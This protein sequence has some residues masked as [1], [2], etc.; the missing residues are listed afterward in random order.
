MKV[1]IYSRVFPPGVGGMERFAVDLADWLTEQGHDVTVA[2]QSPACRRAD[3]ARPYRVLREPNPVAVIAAA[4]R[5]DVV[6]VNGL[7]LR[8]ILPAFAAGR[9]PVVTHHGHHA[10]CPTGLAWVG[11]RLCTAG[12]KPGPCAAC[13]VRGTMAWGKV[14]AH[15]VGLRAA[16]RNVCV[17][18]YLEARLGLTESVAIYNPVARRVPSRPSTDSGDSLLV[19]FAGRLVAEKGLDVLLRALALVPEAQL[20]MAGDGP[21][22]F[23]W[24][25]LAEVLG[26]GT[27]V[28]FRGALTV[29]GVAEL[30]SR[31]ALVCVPSL[32]DEPF[33]Y[34]AA[35]AMAM[36]KA[37]V[38]TPRGALR[39]LL[40]DGRGFVAGSCTPAALANAIRAALDDEARRIRA[41]R[42]AEDF[43]RRELSIDVVGP[44]YLLVYEEA[45]A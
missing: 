24:E 3:A 26:M 39:E 19:A 36:G 27:R 44:R 2:T 40:T 10:I 5:A 11:H 4:R 32:W 1:L 18:R 12:P 43:V 13:P 21:L 22:R 9:R 8:G 14:A 38:A 6:H 37:V 17:S 31:A 30:Y 7:T 16:S 33:G 25:R 34:A 41:G 35:E 45:A 28:T 20:E 15:R 42:L 29:E 23:E